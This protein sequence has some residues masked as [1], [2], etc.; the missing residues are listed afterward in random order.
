MSSLKPLPAKATAALRPISSWHTR[1]PWFL[2]GMTL[3]GIVFG[4]AI[5]GCNNARNGSG[6]GGSAGGEKTIGVAFETLQTEFWV[7]GLDAIK[8]E[9][10]KRGYKVLESVADG[11]S[12]RQL[13]QVKNFIT[14]GVDGIILVPKDAKSCGPMIR[15]ANN[16]KIPITL[17]NRTSD[18]T[19]LSFVS[20]VADNQ[21]LSKKTT[22]HLLTQAKSSDRTIKAI[23]LLGDLGDTNAI[24][25]RD[26]FLEAVKEYGDGIEVVSQVPTEWNQEKCQAGMVNAL[27]ANPDVNLIFTSSDFLLP[28]IV[29]ALK[30]AGRYHPIG[31]PEHVTLGGFDGDATAYQMMQAKYLDAT[32]VQD[33]YFEAEQCV[34]AIEELL[35]GS[36]LPQVIE[37]PGFVIHQGN[38]DEKK[39]QM[40]GAQIS[41]SP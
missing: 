20:V 21:T 35:Q 26:G 1:H 3:L 33:V 16:A 11:D 38:L 12:N 39:E 36:Q 30:S 41:S 9:C 8:R 10:E 6:Q 32:G 28:S 4:G 5:L 34:K 7:A 31:H 22:E 14:K 24:L 27:Q 25:R 23:L 37:D 29:S 15:A 18:S 17:F 2:A 13:Q 40:W 19:D